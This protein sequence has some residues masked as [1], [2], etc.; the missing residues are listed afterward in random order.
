MKNGVYSFPEFA[1][2][3]LMHGNEVRVV[4]SFG[5]Q[6]GLVVKVGCRAEKT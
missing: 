5:S 6:D 4:K 3:G 2:I 1:R